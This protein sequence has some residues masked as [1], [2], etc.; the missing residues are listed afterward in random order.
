LIR[1]TDRTLS[2]ID[3]L[4]HDKVLPHDKSSLLRFLNF[5]IEM[6]P[7]AIELSE[8]MYNFLEPLPE[9]PSYILRL[10]KSADAEKYPDIPEFVCRNAQSYAVDGGVPD[11]E[12]IRS[13]IQLNSTRK[14]PAKTIARYSNYA[15]LRVQGFDYVMCG[16]YLY[17][18]QCLKELFN[19]SIE[20]S[21]QN[22]FHCAT[23]LALEWITSGAGNEVA[24][25]FGGIG[26]FAPTEE[27]VMILREKKLRDENKT[28]TFLPE[29]T[30]LFCRITGK[31]VRLNKPVTGN[32]I[33]HVESGVHV[34]GIL[35]SPQCYEPYPPEI[36]GQKRKIVLGKQSGTA[37][38]KAKLAEFNIDCAEEKIPLILEQVKTKAVKKNGVIFDWEFVK[39]AME[40]KA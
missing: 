6:D 23:A 4:S 27:L 3:D 20:F 35:K 38:I 40:C 26:G 32:R 24:A 16:G 28:Y 11:D 36:V 29:M 12:R 22:S 14:I 15:K 37:S 30:R 10:E 7:G 21:P 9:Y 1:I 18:F 33:F 34:D 17:S 2:C 19:G 5:L 25:S 39:I 8:K 31:Y 13:E